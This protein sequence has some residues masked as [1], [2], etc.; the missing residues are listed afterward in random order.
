MGCMSKF[1]WSDLDARL[2]QLLVRRPAALAACGSAGRF[3]AALDGAG[4]TLALPA[5]PGWRYASCT[6]DVGDLCAAVA[7]PR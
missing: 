7:P 2:L 4:L 5:E 3:A 6:D 1:D